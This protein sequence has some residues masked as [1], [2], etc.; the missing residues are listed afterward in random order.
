[1]NT[2]MLMKI[3]A[4]L[5]AITV[6]YVVVI[7]QPKTEDS[8]EVY[9][10]NLTE[11]NES[12]TSD[13]SIDEV[14]NESEESTINNNIYGENILTIE[15]NNIND[16]LSSDE[17][18]TINKVL[19]KLSVMDCARVNR[20]LQMN[21]YSGSEKDALEFIKKRLLEEDYR[22]IEGILNQYLDLV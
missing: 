7:W 2:K 12:D 15:F 6:F 3:T 17:R 1:M 22:Q 10:E 19:G 9:S 16:K 8:A 13:D 4:C 20:L 11:A 21:N 14:Y 18:N 5:F